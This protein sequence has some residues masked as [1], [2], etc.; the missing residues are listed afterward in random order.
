[1]K[2][3]KPLATFDFAVQLQCSHLMRKD[4]KLI[5]TTFNSNNNN[6]IQFIKW[7][8]CLRYITIVGN[9][10]SILLRIICKI[11]MISTSFEEYNCSSSKTN[12]NNHWPIIFDCCVCFFSWGG[13]RRLPWEPDVL[14]SGLP[15]PTHLYVDRSGFHI[16][17]NPHLCNI[18]AHPFLYY[19]SANSDGMVDCCVSFFLRHALLLVPTFRTPSSRIMHTPPLHQ[20][21]TSNAKDGNA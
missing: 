20:S 2:F 4:Q 11:N 18:R 7:I 14:P 17:L 21:I 16:Q 9:R 8:L 19:L 10:I 6:I 1:M 15:W 12:A 13:L 5:G 3:S